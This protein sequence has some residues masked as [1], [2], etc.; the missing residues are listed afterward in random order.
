MKSGF[1][2]GRTIP[3]GEGLGFRGVWFSDK[4]LDVNEGTASDEVLL[5]VIVDLRKTKFD[6]Y[7]VM[8]EGKPY[9]EWCFPAKLLK[10]AKVL[11]I[12]D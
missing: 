12:A 6:F 4:P 11:Q 1:R 5:E 9:R 7:E 10:K 8:E 2:D 3:F